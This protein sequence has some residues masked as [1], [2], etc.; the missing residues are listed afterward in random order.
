[1]KGVDIM[2]NFN[3]P[4]N[5]FVNNV[6]NKEMNPYYRPLGFIPNSNESY[7]SNEHVREITFPA[8]K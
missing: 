3:Y 4:Y 8:C 1:M 6:R 7:D 5:M 2:N